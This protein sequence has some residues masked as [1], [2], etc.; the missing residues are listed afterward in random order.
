MRRGAQ[1]VNHTRIPM[2]ILSKFAA[3]DDI[4]LRQ[5]KFLIINYYHKIIQQVKCVELNRLPLDWRISNLNLL[6]KKGNGEKG[7]RDNYRG[8]A[9]KAMCYLNRF[10]LLDKKLFKSDRIFSDLKL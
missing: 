5:I 7:K 2:R 9:L 1:R 8:I 6:Y 4:S 10:K 3:N